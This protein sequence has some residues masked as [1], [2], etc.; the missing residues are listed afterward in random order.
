MFVAS[1]I[2]RDL[3]ATAVPSLKGLG[4]FRFSFPGTCVP[5]YPMPPLRGWSL[6][7]VPLS[8]LR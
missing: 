1:Q 7:L 6:G 8:L 4:S 5:G 2:L 3:F